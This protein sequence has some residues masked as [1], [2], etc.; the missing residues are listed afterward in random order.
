M[1]A[2][3]TGWSWVSNCAT[4]AASIFMRGGWHFV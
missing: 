2:S 1:L 3:T 4:A